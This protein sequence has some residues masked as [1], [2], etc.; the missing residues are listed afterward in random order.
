MNRK[1]LRYWLLAGLVA[2]LAACS[3]PPTNEPANSEDSEDTAVAA[4]R[5]TAS[6]TEASTETAEP[7]P[8]APTEPPPT[9]E[10]TEAAP[11][12]TET[13][14]EVPVLPELEL[15]KAYAE[16]QLITLLPPDA[17]PSIDDPQFL[18]ISEADQFYDPN[19]FII[20]VSI[21]GDS[22]AYSIPLLSNHEIVNDMLAG[23][24]IAVTW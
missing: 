6:P 11:A 8:T 10:P 5:Q 14:I 4:N 2:I 7:E 22:R 17:I 13:T 15:A 19:E 3:Q 16:Y 12:T 21:D 20:G 1:Y 23:R 9:L 24:K 18:T